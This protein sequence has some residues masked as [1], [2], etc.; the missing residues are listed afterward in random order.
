M[1]IENG[2]ALALCDRYPFDS[3]CKDIGNGET[4]INVGLSSCIVRPRLNVD[5]YRSGLTL[6]KDSENDTELSQGFPGCNVSLELFGNWKK[7]LK[8]LFIPNLAEPL[9]RSMYCN[10]TSDTKCVICGEGVCTALMV[11]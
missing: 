7:C 11:R 8:V 4:M 1:Y 3:I 6:M 9:G 2:V 10:P 5:N